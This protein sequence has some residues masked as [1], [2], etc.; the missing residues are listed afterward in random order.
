[1]EKVEP[2]T[3]LSLDDITPK[4][5]LSPPHIRLRECL[6]QHGVKYAFIANTLGYQRSWL[7]KYFQGDFEMSEENK[8]KIEALLLPYNFKF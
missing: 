8:S 6:D 1:M 3:T 2:I 4:T 5:P 7:N